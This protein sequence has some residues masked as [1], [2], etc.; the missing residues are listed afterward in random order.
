MT[1]AQDAMYVFDMK[2]A[3]DMHFEFHQTLNCRVI[4]FN[5]IPTE[6]LVKIIH[7]NDNTEMY[8]NSKMNNPVAVL[9]FKKNITQRQKEIELASRAAPQK[10]RGI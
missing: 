3:Q 6:C 7:V 2:Q 8:H 9:N 5:T 1:P 10:P 4:R